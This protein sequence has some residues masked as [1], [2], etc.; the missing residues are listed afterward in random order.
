MR[1]QLEQDLGIPPASVVI[2][3][4]HCHGVIR[5][6]TAQLV[7]QVVKEAAKNLV[8]VKTGSGSGLESRISENRRLKMKDGSEVDMRRAYSMPRDEAVASVGPIDPQVGLLRLDRDAG[9]R[10]RWLARALHSL[11]WQRSVSRPAEPP[12]SQRRQLDDPAF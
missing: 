11:I 6:D 2:N 4:S 12:A 1:G 7:V 9:V 8:V 10:R 3:A 5:A